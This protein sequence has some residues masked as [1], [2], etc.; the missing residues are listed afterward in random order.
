MSSAGA[1][2]SADHKRRLAGSRT[3][4]GSMTSGDGWST[5][6]GND[7][8]VSL[9]L[10]YLIF[11]G[12]LG[13]FALLARSSASK[14]V[15]LLVLRHEVAMPAPSRTP[16]RASTRPTARTSQR[17]SDSCPATAKAP[18][19]HPRHD[20]AWAP[21]AGD[22]FEAT[23]R[24]PLPLPTVRTRR[25]PQFLFPAR[26]LPTPPSSP[27]ARSRPLR[28]LSHPRVSLWQS[29]SRS[30]RWPL[31]ECQNSAAAGLALTPVIMDLS[32]RVRGWCDGY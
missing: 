9:R 7:L 5:T 21:P 13:R 31:L 24:I 22:E 18:S 1:G 17:W 15:E 19:G 20:A 4:P 27:G 12:L 23:D 6:S 16:S 26:Q 3:R 2:R 10:L 30:G 28:D 8:E 14:D 32:G 29:R 11:S 25:G